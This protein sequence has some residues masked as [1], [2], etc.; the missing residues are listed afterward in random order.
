[1]PYLRHLISA[2]YPAQPPTLPWQR[3]L[4]PV[5]PIKDYLGNSRD[6]KPQRNHWIW[7]S[8]FELNI[9]LS[10]LESLIENEYLNKTTIGFRRW[11]SRCVIELS[12]K[13]NWVFLRWKVNSTMYTSRQINY[14]GRFHQPTLKRTQCRREGQRHITRSIP[15][16][17]MKA[18]RSTSSYFSRTCK[19]VTQLTIVVQRLSC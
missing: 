2:R 15:D 10:R 18:A 6:H 9:F 17:L 14:A 7:W 13:P 3:V 4:P 19:M 12:V 11:R 8:R 1:M 5:W 16:R